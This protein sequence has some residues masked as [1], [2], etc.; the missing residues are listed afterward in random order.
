VK[1]IRGLPDES[2]WVGAHGSTRG[3]LSG[4]LLRGI[5][6]PHNELCLYNRFSVSD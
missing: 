5:Y 3:E 4:S 2:Q 1:F 6:S